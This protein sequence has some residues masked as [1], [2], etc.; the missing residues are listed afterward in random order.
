[1]TIAP[2]S[3]GGGG[4]IDPGF[5]VWLAALLFCRRPGPRPARQ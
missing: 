2:A 1:V 5:L 4:A 3:S